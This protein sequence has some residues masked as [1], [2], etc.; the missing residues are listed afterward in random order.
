MKTDCTKA[1]KKRFASDEG[2]SPQ[3]RYFE[4]LKK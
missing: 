3:K 4:N 2:K 1:S